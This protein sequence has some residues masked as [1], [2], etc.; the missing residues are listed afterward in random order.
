MWTPHKVSVCVVQNCVSI[1][2]FNSTQS[3]HNLVSL[4]PSPLVLPISP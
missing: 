3:P 2:F 4:T 1:E